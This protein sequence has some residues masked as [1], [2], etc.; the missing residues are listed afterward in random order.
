MTGRGKDALR[1][2]LL[3]SENAFSSIV[4]KRLLEHGVGVCGLVLH[5]GGVTAGFAGG[6]RPSLPVVLANTAPAVALAHDCPVIRLTDMRDARALAAAR[7]LAPDLVLVACF[8]LI[9]T[10]AWRRL[11]Q[12][13]A[14]NLHPALL[15]AYRG[16]TPLFWQLRAGVREVGVSLHAV[17]AKVDSGGI[18]AQHRLAIAAGERFDQ[19]NAKLAAHG[20]DLVLRVLGNL[21]KGVAMSYAPQDEARA[22]Y[23]GFPQEA[24][25]RIDATFGAQRAFQFIEGTREAGQQYRF[26]AGDQTLILDRA[27]AVSL[28]TRL[29]TAYEKHAQRLRI[30]FDDG[31]L[32]ARGRSS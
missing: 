20:A 14:L 13:A 25:Y 16:P 26:E 17:T 12:V 21:G 18:V 31:V 8:P 4:L 30:Q 7:E 22:S 6:S 24:H 29:G 23:Q 5:H 11:A 19:I 2:L 9:L 3:G 1:V 27:Y 10:Q 28:G 15:P 32:E